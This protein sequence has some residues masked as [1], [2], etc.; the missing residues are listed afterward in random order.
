MHADRLEFP[1]RQSLIASF[2]VRPLA[3]GRLIAVLDGASLAVRVG[4]L[5]S[6]KV[7]LTQIDRIGT[8][9]WPW[10]AGAGVR[11]SK[12][13]VAFVPSTGEVAVVGL[14][15]PLAVRA[16]LKWTTGRLAI[17]V[18]DVEGF[19]AAVDRRCGGLPRI[20]GEA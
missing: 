2:L 9:R 7:P 11:I 8:M 12:N 3:W 16:P 14:S 13:L 18:E 1:L 10:W 4:W 6:A 20:E 5:G 15:A 19:I 17:A